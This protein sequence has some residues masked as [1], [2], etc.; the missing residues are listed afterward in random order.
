MPNKKVKKSKPIKDIKTKEII[1]KF[2]RTNIFL[3]I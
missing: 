2:E 3:F 1:V